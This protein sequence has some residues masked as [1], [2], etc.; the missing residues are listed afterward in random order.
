MFICDK[1]VP[2]YRY[3]SRYIISSPLKKNNNTKVD[4]L[5][6]CKNVHATIEL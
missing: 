6:R 2:E 4:T 3:L 1:L 5:Y